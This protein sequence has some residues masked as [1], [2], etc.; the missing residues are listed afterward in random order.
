MNHKQMR[1]QGYVLLS[2]LLQRPDEELLE[3]AGSP[4]V[5]EFWKQVERANHI[6]F[7]MSWE[8]AALP[9]LA[10]WETMWNVTMGPVK[11]LAEPIESLYKPWTIDPSCE[12]T[13]ATQTGW[14]KGDWGCH[15][16]EMLISLGFEIP[17]Q[18]AHC[19]DHLVL[20]LEFMSAI[21][22]EAPEEVQ[23][24]FIEHHLD[25]LRDLI[26]T[27]RERNVPQIYQD[28]Y[29]WCFDYVD[30]DLRTLKN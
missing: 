4:Q 20:E 27:A 23:I 2:Q 28:L 30:A 11:P 7:P 26:D 15:M 8:I 17:P 24:N 3:I 19:P 25:W 9:D 6:T 18:F 10:E 13:I 29:R 16:E 12:M 22:A 21:I 1:E 5:R 14:L